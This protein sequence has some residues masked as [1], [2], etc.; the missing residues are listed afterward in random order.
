MAIKDLKA[1]D[2]KVDVVVKVV[3]KG[4]VREFSKF[5]R[6]GRV[7][8]ATVKDETGE[9]K[10]SLWNEQVDQV[11]VGDSVHITNGYVNEFQGDLQLTTGRFG[12][13]EVLGNDK[14]AEAVTEDEMDEEESLEGLKD[15]EGEH[16]L[17]ED[18]KE[19][20]TVEEDVQEDEE[21]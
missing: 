8:T 17:T 1:R 9:I 15:D 7:C 13:L 4:D 19:E 20:E 18:E 21:K 6:S 14:K 2:Q 3:E 16:V 11:K 5:G 10:L 12:K